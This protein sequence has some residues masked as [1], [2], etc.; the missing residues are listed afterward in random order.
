VLTGIDQLWVADITYST[1]F[2]P[3]VSLRYD[4]SLLRATFSAGRVK[5]EPDLLFWFGVDRRD[6]SP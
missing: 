1:P 4:T 3:F 2:L 5:L 6:T